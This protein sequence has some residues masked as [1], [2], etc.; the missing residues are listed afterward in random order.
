MP[1]PALCATKRAIGVHGRTYRI[2]PT[3]SPI[4]GGH[5]PPARETIDGL[6]QNIGAAFACEPTGR[7]AS[8]RRYETVDMRLL[9]KSRV[10]P[11]V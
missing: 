9:R 6:P 1:H 2:A 3:T 11:A 4:R 7:R 10:C 5:K 8:R